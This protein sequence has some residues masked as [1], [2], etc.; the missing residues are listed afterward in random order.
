MNR[1]D[2]VRVNSGA[3]LPWITTTPYTGLDG[4]CSVLVKDKS[5]MRIIAAF[6]SLA[7]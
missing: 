4:Q 1:N 5:Q 7:T 2:H 6:V 3:A